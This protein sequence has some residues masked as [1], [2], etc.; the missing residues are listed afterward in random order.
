[1]QEASKQEQSRSG[2]SPAWQ[3][4]IGVYEPAHDILEQ[5]VNQAWEKYQATI[6]PAW[7]EWL[8]ESG[9]KK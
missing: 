4:F 9:Q 7:D 8:R 5:E 3:K 6:A 2:P 1:M